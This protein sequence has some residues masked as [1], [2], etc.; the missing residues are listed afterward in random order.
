MIICNP[1]LPYLYGRLLASQA[2][3]SYKNC[4]SRLNNTI[5]IIPP[6]LFAY[7]M[8]WMYPMEA[9]EAPVHSWVISRIDNG[10]RG[11]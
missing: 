4:P 3:H 5:I 8:V 9:L 6:I 1:D 7:K 2:T 11:R 10:K